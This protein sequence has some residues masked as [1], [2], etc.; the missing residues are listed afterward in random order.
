MK[1]AIIVASKHG[2]T[3]EIAE[4]I[5]TELRAHNHTADL[6]DVE[7]VTE[8]D[9]YGAVILGSAI[10]GGNWLTKAM[11]FTKVFQKELLQIPVWLFSSGPLN[12][13]TTRPQADR[14]K[15]TL[16]LGEIKPRDH[17]LFVGK[18]DLADLGLME[19]ML[20]SAMR[21]STGDYRDWDDIRGWARGIAE[22]LHKADVPTDAV[23]ATVLL[24]D[25]PSC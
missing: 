6:L 8:L 1:V 19:R 16:P 7:Y 13:D 21:I 17:H 25:C 4:A 20:V 18:L 9:G 11:R 5:T 24:P 15:P 3:R 14:P 12:A 2:S 10:Y 22:E 23:R